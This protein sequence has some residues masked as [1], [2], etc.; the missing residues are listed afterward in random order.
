MKTK[1]TV[2]LHSGQAP[3]YFYPPNG[4]KRLSSFRPD[5]HGLVWFPGIKYRVTIE[6]IG[7]ER[8]EWGCGP[9][10]EEMQGWLVK[11]AQFYEEHPDRKKKLLAEI[12]CAKEF[13]RLRKELEMMLTTKKPKK[14]KKV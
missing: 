14:G 10:L 2:V 7:H 4:E 3:W 9:T 1:A 8:E 13:V 11:D 6:A 12:L 5:E